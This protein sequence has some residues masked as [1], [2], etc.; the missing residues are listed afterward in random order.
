VASLDNSRL[1]NAVT[2]LNETS[3]IRDTVSLGVQ[4]LR[5][6][7]S[8]AHFFSFT[9]I[10]SFIFACLSVLCSAHATPL[11][12]PYVCVLYP[13]VEEP[14]ARVTNEILKGIWERL[15]VPKPCTIELSEQ[16]DKHVVQSW[17]SSR[18]PSVVI[19][20][21][22]LA[23]QLFETS[24]SRL[25]YVIGALDISPDTRPHASG[26]SLAVDPGVMFDQL[27]NMAPMVK[28][29]FLV[30]EPGH[31]HWLLE[32]AKKDTSAYGLELHAEPA[33]NVMQGAERYGHLVQIAEPHTDAIWLTLNNVIIDDHSLVPYLIEQAWYRKVIIV[34]NKLEH[35][36]W[37]VLFA[38]YPNNRA[39]GQR[40]AETALT[41][42][43]LRL[44]PTRCKKAPV[45]PR[46][47]VYW[48]HPQ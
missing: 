15:S 12:S 8:H 19:T 5:N 36:R 2:V 46:N 30:Y 32:R 37:G 24:G 35:A 47:G 17:L 48:K 28:R 27:R 40:L 4:G 34:S 11:Q 29:V 14:Y 6:R 1:S 3:E 18:A 31:D 25:P 45:V 38:T 43:R 33:A 22:R 16:A 10:S 41:L 20:L 26:I 21:G 13:K 39:L 9:C 23:T 7:F 42:T 44:R